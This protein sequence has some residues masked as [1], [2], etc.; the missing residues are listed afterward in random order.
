MSMKKPIRFLA[1]V[2][3]S[4]GLTLVGLTTAQTEQAQ[5]A[6]SSC[7]SGDACV[8]AKTNYA[9]KNGRFAQCINSFYDYGINDT[10][11]SVWN[12]GNQDTVYLYGHTLGKGSRE[13]RP[14]K[15][16][17]ETMPPGW[18]KRISS[19]YFA[20]YEGSKGAAVCN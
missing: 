10:T 16:G 9:A 13:S 3:A 15:A 17:Y 20:S 2:L 1:T 11:L 18:N 14:T 8:Y 5:A 4:V 12:A 7:A 6:P 19:A